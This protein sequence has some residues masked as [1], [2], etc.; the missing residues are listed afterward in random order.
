MNLA[1]VS[2]RRLLSCRCLSAVAALTIVSGGWLLLA[3]HGMAAD[4][5][6]PAGNAAESA[7]PAAGPERPEMITGETEASIRKGLALLAR[8]QSRDG[9]WRTSTGYP[10]AMTALAG[11]AFLAAG[12]T[13]VEGEYSANVR[14][15]IDYLISNSNSSGLIAKV[16]E[17]HSS[18]HGHGFAMLFLAEAYGMDRDTTR[19]TRIR[20]VLQKAIGLTGASQS[21]LGGWLYQPNQNSDEGSVTVTQIQGLRACRNAGIKVPK[22]IIDKACDYI[23]KSA[24]ADG[25]ISYRVGMPGSRPPITA[26]AVATLYNAGQYEN[27]VAL[28][29]LEYVKK[30]IKSGDITKL[31]GGH[32]FYSLLYASQAMYLSSD[33]NWKGFFPGARDRLLR[34]QNSNGGWNGD[35]MGEVYGT[36]IALIALQLP[37]GYMPIFQR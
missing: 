11:M 32:E 12:N 15:A 36:S 35:G 22:E 31:G 17:E 4:E 29:A 19:Q 9:S 25:G 14:S 1:L 18:M 26:A 27:P 6:K 3:Q 20:R 7:T 16:D 8:L 34:T 13:P 37:Y 21:R 24:N 23:A 30:L 10:T 33:E 28:K 5:A 2:S